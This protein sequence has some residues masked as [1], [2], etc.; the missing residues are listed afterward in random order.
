MFSYSL[1]RKQRTDYILALSLLPVSSYFPI[2]D[3]SFIKMYSNSL[4]KHLLI[5]HYVL[6][7]FDARQAPTITDLSF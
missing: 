5:S 6:I 4:K 2:F 1:F 3:S 7:I